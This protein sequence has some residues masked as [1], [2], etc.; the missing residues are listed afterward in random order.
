MQKVILSHINFPPRDVQNRVIK[1]FL[2]D[3]N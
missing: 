1:K 3:Y 2:W